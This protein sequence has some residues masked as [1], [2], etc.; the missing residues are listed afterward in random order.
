M[1][2]KLHS[3]LTDD[4][5]HCMFTGSVE[6]EHHHVYGGANKKLSERYGFIAPLR[7]DLHPNG[8]RADK[9]KAYDIDIKLKKMCQQYWLDHYGTKQEFIDVFQKK[10]L[11]D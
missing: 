7:Y 10:W 6:I 9:N 8:V 11:L 4:M 2:K 3:V 5:D 1:T